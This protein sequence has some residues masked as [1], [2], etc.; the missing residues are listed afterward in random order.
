MMRR[1]KGNGR[2]LNNKGMSLVEVLVAMTI[3]AIAAI[4][5]LRSFTYASH[6]NQRSREKQH[7]LT[8]AQSIMES[9][10][11]YDMYDIYDQFSGVSAFKVYDM[12]AVGGASYATMGFGNYAM[13]NV[14]YN[15]YDYDVEISVSDVPAAEINNTNMVLKADMPTIASPNQYSDAFFVQNYAGEMRCILEDIWNKMDSDANGPSYPG[16]REYL[17]SVYPGGQSTFVASTD[18]SLVEVSERKIQVNLTG[19]GSSSQVTVS[20]TYDYSVGAVSYV[21]LTGLPAQYPAYDSVSRTFD[22]DGS[23]EPERYLCFDNSISGSDVELENTYLY[24]YPAYGRLDSYH[25]W[26]KCNQDTILINNNTGEAKN[27]F[28]IKQQLNV[29]NPTTALLEP[30]TWYKPDVGRTGAEVNLY[31]NLKK[32]LANMTGPELT[33]IDNH[34]TGF[35][36]P[37]SNNDFLWYKEVDKTLV[38]NIKIN[39]MAADSG[40]LLYTLEGSA[41][42]K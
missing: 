17:D 14:S 41:N 10:K 7:A 36:D 30:E 25:S 37:S 35:T 32:N 9:F 5:F 4:G 33:N 23:F 21:D 26:F 38:Y 12:A 40:D 1:K 34:I 20:V 28:L 11:A 22:K 13:S 16:L 18:K 39:V 8:L 31:H 29:P 6:Y 19:S 42:T 24:F 3:L 27:V 15:G 2:K